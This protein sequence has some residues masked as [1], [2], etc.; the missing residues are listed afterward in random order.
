M[1][2][3]AVYKDHLRQLEHGIKG[4]GAESGNEW[5]RKSICQESRRCGARPDRAGFKRKK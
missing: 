1:M 5:T 3:R 2:V 4:S